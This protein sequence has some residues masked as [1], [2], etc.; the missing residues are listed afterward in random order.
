MKIFLFITLLFISAS[1]VF[2]QQF[3]QWP[4]EE[5]LY[6]ELYKG[7]KLVNSTTGFIIKSATQNYLIL[8]YHKVANKIWKQNK[9]LFRK[10]SLLNGYWVNSMAKSKPDR[11]AIY[12]I[13]K[14][15]GKRVV[16]YENL[17]G[18]NGK[19]LWHSFKLKNGYVDAVALPLKDT[20]D[21][22]IYPVD[23]MNSKEYEYTSA[24]GLLV[25]PADSKPGVT[26]VKERGNKKYLSEN[27]Y[28]A[29]S[30]SPVYCLVQNE[31]VFLGVFSHAPSV[32]S[33]IVRSKY[34]EKHFKLLP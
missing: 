28:D 12:H 29:L 5:G 22:D 18:T 33:N 32:R 13:A 3:M 21:V 20:A 2:S 8:N 27:D 4:S 24:I 14:G 9:P 6:I 7:N 25:Y 26:D 11:I 30:G 10:D 16:K 1:S 23:Y 19:N 31:P 17:T 34:L 15:N